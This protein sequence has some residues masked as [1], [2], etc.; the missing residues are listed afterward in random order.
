MDSRRGGRHRGPDRSD[1]SSE[2]REF[3]RG[4]PQERSNCR[5]RHPG[6]GRTVPIA[7]TGTGGDR[8][9][10]TRRG[11]D[12]TPRRTNDLS[13]GAGTAL[14]GQSSVDRDAAAATT[15]AAAGLPLDTVAS[16]LTSATFRAMGTSTTVAVAEAGALE[17]A[18][19][20]AREVI[21]AVDNTCSRFKATSELSHLNRAAGG[22]PK[23][24]SRLLA[25]AISAALDAA[26]STAGLVDPTM[27]QLIA[28]LGYSVSFGEMALNGP[29]VEVEVRAAPGWNTVIHDRANGTVQLPEAVAIDLGAAGKSWA[30]DRAAQAAAQRTGCGVLVECGGDVSLAGPPPA[31]GW[32]VRV[33]E[34]PGAASRQDILAF[35]GG[36]ATSGTGSRAWQRG[37]RVY[38]HILDPATGLPAASPWRTVSVAAASCAQANAA[39]TAAIILGE[40][41]Q[42][43]LDERRLPAR[44]VDTGGRVVTLGAWPGQR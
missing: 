17:P 16:V 8:R 5:A 1:L 22:P 18:L 6:G 2:R 27:G 25:D 12:G 26:A 31:S 35:D 33:S 40:Q 11:R 24:V 32:C 38:H 28:R 19:R 9:S 37:G 10:D 43:W 34:R 14:S 39:A 30:A 21:E 44:L 7:A 3:R 20:A 42:A 13:A 29:G 4:Q 41:A 23:R 36:I 15:T